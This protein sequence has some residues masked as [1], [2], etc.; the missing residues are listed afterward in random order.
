[1]TKFIT[2][3]ALKVFLREIKRHIALAVRQQVD[4]TYAELVELRDNAKLIAGC[5]YRIT[6]YVTKVYSASGFERSAEHPFDII[7]RALSENTLAEEAYVA[8]RKGDEYFVNA[9]LN[10]WKVWYCLDNDV[11][12]YTWA[13]VTNGKGVIYRMIDEWQNDMPY[14]FKN[15]QYR[16]YRVNDDS[17]NGELADLDG[18]WLAWSETDSPN[19]L[20]VTSEFVWCYTF[21]HFKLD[22]DGIAISQIP[23]DATVYFY[24][25]DVDFEGGGYSIAGGVEN[26]RMYARS[27][28]VYI[29]DTIG[30]IG[31]A[32]TNIVCH[33]YNNWDV[34]D[35]QSDMKSVKS[36]IWRPG[37]YDITS[38]GKFTANKLGE[39]NHSCVYGYGFANITFGNSCGSLTFGN[40]C[41]DMTFGNN[42][43][44]LTFGNDCFEMT[45]GNNNRYLTFGNNNR[46][47][48]F[49]N[50]N[51]YLTFGNDCFEMTFGNICNN[52]T[53]GN[54]N[55]YLTFGNNNYYLTFGNSCGSLTFGNNNRY[56]TFGNDCWRLTFGNYCYWMTFGNN[57]HNGTVLDGVSNL[58]IL[59]AENSNEA[60]QNFVILTG[61]SPS[62]NKKAVVPFEKGKKYTQMAGINSAGN[63]AVWIPADVA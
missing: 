41:S 14:D 33:T 59:G 35:G 22:E 3:D 51:Y 62:D 47:L 52:L 11:T 7:V 2:L 17:P 61:T 30:N 16:R 34:S 26:N 19:N 24:E 39:A 56:L 57:V 8:P 23:Y 42:N 38:L 6:D 58:E 49:G 21:N 40:G 29:D 48:T 46:Y 12:K 37:C 54:N 13:D 4:V 53:F 28:T 43:R 20:S 32:L 5:L 1:M 60:V 63:L 9:N 55:Y 50:N 44:Y 31:Q 15:V 25:K 45:F 18:H 36:N 10:A 27:C